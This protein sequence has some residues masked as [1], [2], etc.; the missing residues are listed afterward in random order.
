MG[1]HASGFS[2]LS[3]DDFDVDKYIGYGEKAVEYGEKAMEYGEKAY[4]FLTG[5]S[6]KGGKCVVKGID[7]NAIKAK[8]DLISFAYA[9]IY[10][11]LQNKSSVPSDTKNL[12]SYLRK[13]VT[14]SAV[15]YAKGESDAVAKTL[16][17]WEK[18]PSSTKTVKPNVEAL[19]IVSSDVALHS[20]YLE[21]NSKTIYNL[22]KTISGRIPSQQVAVKATQVPHATALPLC[23]QPKYSP[24]SQ[25]GYS[26]I[27]KLKSTCG[28]KPTW[29]PSGADDWY[30]G[31]YKTSKEGNKL[32]NWKAATSEYI[33]K[34]KKAATSDHPDLP[35]ST[36]KTSDDT[37]SMK[38]VLIGGGVLAVVGIGAIIF[39]KKRKK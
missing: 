7:D 6:K 25:E 26:K 39:L 24:S 2:S 5:G 22:S 3:G 33:E 10:G 11:D 37:S 21:Q 4:D 28:G 17:Q 12:I 13:T 29:V 15:T 18:K 27:T 14:G 30:I 35:G 34:L 38:Y 32:T 16:D 1:I 31:G 19:D 23:Q 20:C 9:S 8:K 36:T